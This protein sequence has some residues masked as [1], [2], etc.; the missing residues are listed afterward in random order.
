MVGIP[1]LPFFVPTQAATQQTTPPNGS[2]IIDLPK[3][4]QQLTT[5]SSLQ[6]IVTNQTP[7]GTVTVTTSQGTITL[8][9]A[10]LL[11]VG[12]ELVFNPKSSGSSFILQL[13]QL[14]QTPAE[15]TVK[16]HP[17]APLPTSSSTPENTTKSLLNFQLVAGA[18]LSADPTPSTTSTSPLTQQAVQFT[19]LPSITPN[20]VANGLLPNP[21]PHPF[22]QL[23]Q[24]LHISPATQTTQ[25][26][27][28]DI[29]TFSSTNNAPT[30]T[31]ATQ[32]PGSSAFSQGAI[33][34]VKVTSITP[35]T[36]SAS[37]TPSSAPVAPN[38][39]PLQLN[40]TVIP[41]A[42][43]QTGDVQLST[44]LGTL[45]LSSEKPLPQGTQLSLEIIALAPTT[46]QTASTASGNLTQSLQEA[47]PQLLKHWKTLG[48]VADI[49]KQELPASSGT[50]HSTSPSSAKND[51]PLDALLKSFLP[52]PDK[53][54]ASK[55]LHF[56]NSI[57]G[58][59]IQQWVGPQ[60]VRLLEKANQLPLLDKLS[61]EFTMIGK[62]FREHTPSGW[63]LLLFPLYDGDE[64]HQ[65]RMYVKH[66]QH[67]GTDDDESY[68]GTRF[69]VDVD[70]SQLGA[71]QFDG[72]VRSHNHFK[73]FDLILR[74]H[75]PLSEEMQQDIQAIYT[76][77]SDITGMKGSISFQTMEE[78]P[79]NPEAELFTE[80]SN[81]SI[82]A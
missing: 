19:P 62:I 80:G 67:E 64:I 70:L 9:T 68:E 7:G 27:T 23:L 1:F 22:S 60:V 82:L 77:A 56:T 63:Q 55:L 44:P 43:P 45:T 66:F 37:S 16:I 24:H 10:L 46:T 36:V 26:Q 6:G 57:K 35:P 73:H 13:T 3:T 21:S 38:A 79:V 40:A 28:P 53:S 69:I 32:N 34:T 4:I 61:D 14:N 30:S 12:S 41:S 78:F 47:L 54:L 75:K 76:E 52:S 11:P 39:N 25:G 15:Q 48:D 5:G 72:I 17:N 81:N 18:K 31:A 42:N 50:L 2:F 49:I 33:V 20:I 58:G 59:D 74:S 51:Q 29:N 65:T 8:S 71:I